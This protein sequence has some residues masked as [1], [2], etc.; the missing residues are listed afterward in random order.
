MRVLEGNQLPLITYEN[1]IL[2][3]SKFCTRLY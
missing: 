1:I 3:L 2:I